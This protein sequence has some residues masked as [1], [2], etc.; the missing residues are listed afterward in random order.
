MKVQIED[1]SSVK[2]KITVNFPKE[3][4]DEELK[5]ELLKIQKTAE[6]KGFRK[7]KAPYSIVEKIYMPEAM[8]RYSER[9]IKDSLQ[10]I[11]TEHNLDIATRPIVEKED[12]TDEGF[13]YHA[14]VEVHPKVELKNYK[15]LTFKKKKVEITEEM[16]DA[17]IEEM[18]ESRVKTTPLP[19]GEKSDIDC[20]VTFDVL[21]YKLNG[22]DKGSFQ[23]ENVD[24]RKEG[25]FKEIK[26]ALTNVSV[27]EIKEFSF[28]YP[29]DMD[30]ENLK[31]K[32]A[33]LKIM[34]KNIKKRIYLNNEELAKELGYNSLADMRE[35]FRKQLETKL[36]KESEE[37]FKISI[38]N[39]LAE[40]NP[41]EVPEGMIEELAIKMLEDFIRNLE[42]S[43]LNPEKLQLDWKNMYEL[44]KKQAEIILKRH[45]IMKAIKDLENIDVSEEEINS[46]VG[47][48]IEKAQDREKASV[49]FENPKVRNNIY[50]DIFESKVIDFLK[51]NNQIVEE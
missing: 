18:R 51:N 8:R 37:E 46:R 35:A 1:L 14:I 12:F 6:I 28:T 26:D 40:E 43:G 45:Y 50:M 42:R 9:I 20:F 31:G 41:F 49:Y 4:V 15:G 47:E 33:D 38:F 5:K 48:L 36:T 23:N 24:L 16:I 11:T 39:K 3:K 29:E 27:G 21:E 44:N 34:I 2:K 10:S 7:G 30:D 22:E 25:I 32:K 19:E 17:K 13:E